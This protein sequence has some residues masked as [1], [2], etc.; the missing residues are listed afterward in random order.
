VPPEAEGARPTIEPEP[1]QAFWI[2]K[3]SEW[4]L[5]GWGM[6][7]IAEELDHWGAPLCAYTEQW[8][9]GSVKTILTNPINA[10]YIDLINKEDKRNGKES[11]L[12]RGQHYE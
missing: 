12:I 5:R 6:R 7:R 1:K 8:S 11:E 3:I 10:G 4:F 9:R 2:P